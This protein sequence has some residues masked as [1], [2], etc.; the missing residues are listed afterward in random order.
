MY[1]WLEHISVDQYEEKSIE[2][3]SFLDEMKAK[4]DT[5]F[6]IP[7]LSQYHPCYLNS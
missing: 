3:M 6:T 1:E 5:A 4:F 7:F 2:E